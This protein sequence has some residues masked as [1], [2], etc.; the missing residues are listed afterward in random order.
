MFVKELREVAGL[1]LRLGFTAFGGPA[2]H[3]AMMR[4]EAVVKRAWLSDEEFLDLVGVTNLIPGPNST[5]LAIHLGYRRAGRWGLVVAGACF[6]VPAM[7]IV[8]IL[9]WAY[10]R[11]GALPAM[12]GLLLGMKPVVVAIVVQ[13]LVGLGKSTLKTASAWITAI[14]VL[15]LSLAFGVGELWLVFLPGLA[16]ALFA[17]TRKPEP[18]GMKRV[19]ATSGIVG[20]L[21]VVSAGLAFFAVRHSPYSLGALFLVFLKVGSVLY[22]SGYVLL[23]Y[24]NT[25]LVVRLGWLTKSQLLDAISVGQFTPGP[26]FTAA[27]FVG[28]VL[29]GVPGAV[30]ATLGI[31]LPSF[32][33]VG[34]SAKWLEIL[35]QSPTTQSFIA[36]VNASSLGLMGAVVVTLA[37]TALIDIWTVAIGLVSLGVLLK[38]KVNSVWLVLGGAVLGLLLNRG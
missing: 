18:V 20:A 33:L 14:G 12:K 22:G 23:S 17:Y 29:G 16:F 28:Y 11:F 31:F 35:K 19:L 24:L 6:I 13:A 9:A 15:A 21:I 10:V 27:T 3:I 5:E 2:A 1:F 38:T 7:L 36:G 34:A 30:V 25:D 8:I 4:Q 26:V 32:I 37:R